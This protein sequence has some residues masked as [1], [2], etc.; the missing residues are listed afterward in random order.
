MEL[1]AVA[2]VGH[3]VTPHIRADAVIIVLLGHV[4]GQHRVDVFVITVANSFK[5]FL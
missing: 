2:N 5:L 4:E 3:H 1:R